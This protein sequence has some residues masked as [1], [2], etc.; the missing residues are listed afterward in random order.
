LY[1]G[2]RETPSRF[3]TG[4]IPAAYGPGGYKFKDFL[5]IGTPMVLIY[6]SIAFT[7]IVLIYK[8]I[9]ID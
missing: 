8:D 6:L 3:A 4:F 5:R 2:K 9:L 7:L 1:N